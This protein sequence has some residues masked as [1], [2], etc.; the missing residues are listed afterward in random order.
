MVA[1]C[2]AARPGPRHTGER[3]PVKKGFDVPAVEGAA[4][5]TAWLR[6]VGVDA[7]PLAYGITDAE[8]RI[9]EALN[10]PRGR[11]FIGAAM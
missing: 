8:T 9:L 5:L 11:N 4:H 6:A 1:H 10:S 3:A 2:L 7:S